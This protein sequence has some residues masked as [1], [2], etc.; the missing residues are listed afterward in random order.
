MPDDRL[1]K[2]TRSTTETT[3]PTINDQETAQLIKAAFVAHFGQEDVIEQPPS[4]MG[5][6]DFSYYIAPALGVKGV[7]FRVGGTPEREV[8]TAPSH[9]SP[10][11]KIEPRPAI[12]AGVE[13]MV[14]GAMT[15]LAD[16]ATAAPIQ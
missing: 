1:P 11:F 9:H 12:T 6:E 14:V 2:V 7:F 5:A 16:R 10:L 3:A 4:G 8:A 13:A 15:L